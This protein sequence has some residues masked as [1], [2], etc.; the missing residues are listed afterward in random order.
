MLWLCSTD[1]HAQQTPNKRSLSTAL[2]KVV[3]IATPAEHITLADWAMTLP[4]PCAAAEKPVRVSLGSGVVRWTHAAFC[5]L[6]AWHPPINSAHPQR[7][8]RLIAPLPRAI[9]GALCSIE[10]S[11]EKSGP[12][13]PLTCTSGEV[14]LCGMLLQTDAQTRAC[15]R[16][17]CG[18][19]GG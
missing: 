19:I 18:H 1:H 6:D 17:F 14:I 4:N 12:P 16:A 7:F 3:E 8:L 15:A 10:R 13:K 2:L 11:S 9:R 5:W